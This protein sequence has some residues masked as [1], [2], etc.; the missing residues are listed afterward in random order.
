MTADLT[1]VTDLSV[2]SAR[3]VETQRHLRSTGRH[4]L[5]GMALWAGVVEGSAAKIIEVIIPQQDGLRTEHGL[6]V[7]VPGPELHRINVHLFKNKLRLIAQVHS[8]PTE[9]YHSDTDDRYAIATALGSFSIVVPD[10]ATGPFDINDFATYRL[11]KGRWPWDRS[12]RW[13][14]LSPK[15]AAQTIRIT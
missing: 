8:H 11:L 9:A 4:G 13:R 7:T 12:P 5:E 6:A 10:F 2:A 15:A 1:A 3:A 14:A